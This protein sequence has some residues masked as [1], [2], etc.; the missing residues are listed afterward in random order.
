MASRLRKPAEEAT[1]FI[2]NLEGLPIIVDDESGRRI[3]TDVHRLAITHRLTGYDAAY[4]EL[5]LRRNLPMAT[6]DSELIA[7]CG[8]AG[9]AVL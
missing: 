3:L 5:A 1:N 2:A 4:L 8:R 6:L 7:A 9:V